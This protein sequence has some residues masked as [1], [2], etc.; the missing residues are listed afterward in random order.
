MDSL[1]QSFYIWFTTTW[2][3]CRNTIVKRLFGL[4]VDFWTSPP[5]WYTVPQHI[6]S[7]DFFA[8]WFFGT[9][10]T[11]SSLRFDFQFSKNWWS[12][13]LALGFFT[14]TDLLGYIGMLSLNPSIVETIVASIMA[15][16]CC[17]SSH[18]PEDLYIFLIFYRNLC[19]YIALL[20]K[21][22][23]NPMVTI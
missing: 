8:L 21:D 10:T 9:K 19:L 3:C 7:S 4:L 13:F 14:V 1:R 18:F 16:Y 20:L 17:W 2:G 5:L 11:D 15:F 22:W 23:S 12:D 6:V